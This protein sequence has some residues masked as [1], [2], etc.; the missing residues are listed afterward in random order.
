MQTIPL[1]MSVDFFQTLDRKKITSL[2]KLDKWPMEMVAEKQILTGHSTVDEIADH[3]LAY[4]QFMFFQCLHPDLR[5]G[6]FSDIVDGIWHQHI[7]FTQDYER[8]GLEIFGRFIHHIPGNVMDSSDGA[9]IEYSAWTTEF[10]SVFGG[11]L[12]RP[13]RAPLCQGSGG[14]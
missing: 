1:N 8:F 13:Q 6:I 14:T 7:L 12:I 11:N 9:L 10:E 2:I 5:C 4:K 3:I